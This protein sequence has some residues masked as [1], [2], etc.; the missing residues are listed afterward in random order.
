M[1]KEVIATGRTVDAAIDS[2]CAEL[3]L[4]RGDVDFEIISMPKKGFLG[5]SQI[6]AKVRV[7][8]QVPDPKPALEQ[9]PAPQEEKPLPH[10]EKP[11]PKSAAH[12]AQPVRE[13]EPKAEE[14]QPQA[15]T[16]QPEPPPSPPPP[17]ISAT[18][19]PSPRNTSPRFCGR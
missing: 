7:F 6:P 16:V 1:M 13:E 4:E 19:L 18:R 14:K 8:V 3:G 5:L 12:K 10:E 15:N 11:A 9:K 17:V 2:G